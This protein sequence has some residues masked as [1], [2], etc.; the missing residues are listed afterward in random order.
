MDELLLFDEE[1][2][3]LDP[4]YLPRRMLTDFS[5]YNAEVWGGCVGCVC[6]VWCVWRVWE[7]LCERARRW[8]RVGAGATW[9]WGCL[10]GWG[11]VPVEREAA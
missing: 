8:E 10:V 2:A 7:A 1:V 5:L 4:E 3:E 11:A 9:L 6:C